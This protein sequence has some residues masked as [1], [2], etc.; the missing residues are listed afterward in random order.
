MKTLLV[1]ALAVA[2]IAT[3]CAVA[4]P[5]VAYAA[6]SAV[7]YMAMLA[8]PASPHVMPRAILGRVRAEAP[9]ALPARGSHRVSV[10]SAIPPRAIAAARVRAD[11]SDPKVVIT[12][13]KA[14]FEAFKTEND[15]KLKAKAD[16]VVDEKVERINSAVTA[17]QA[18]LDEL[19]IKLA[20]EKVKPGNLPGDLEATS[21]EAIK[22]FKTF[23]RRGDEVNAALTKSV[24]TEGGYLAPVEWDRT[25]VDKLKLISKVRENARVLPITV[26]GFK[27]LFNDR[28]VGSGWVGETASRP[29]TTTP[30]IGSLD[31]APGELYA[32]PAISSGLLQD[33]AIDLEAWLADEVEVEFSRQEGIAFLS[34][35]GT[36]KPHGLLTYVTGAANAARHPWGAIQ[37]VNSGAPRRS[38]ATASST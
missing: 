33:A 36:N 26:A 16:V 27:K 25:I 24:D 2:L 4:A 29:A 8:L 28:A 19:A 1:A 10:A 35:D 15:A 22:A 11:V 20:A 37:V 32:N 5:D 17:M 21:P 7:P 34:G 23:M 9:H 38:R 3:C 18:A 30:A 13:L 12:E 6:H 31:W 14:A